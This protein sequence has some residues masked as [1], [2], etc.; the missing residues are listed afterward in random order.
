MICI[1][2]MNFL[3]FSFFFAGGGGGGFCQCV[4]VDESF[5]NLTENLLLGFGFMSVQTQVTSASPALSAH[6]LKC[7][8]KV[9]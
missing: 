5:T 1:V 9:Y 2:E 7:L 4:N 3:F 8:S 6:R